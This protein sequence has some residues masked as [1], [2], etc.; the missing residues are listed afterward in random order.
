[1]PKRASPAPDKKPAN[2]GA[3][4]SRARGGKDL[5]IVESPAKAR[6]IEGILGDQYRVIASVGHVRDLP[7]YGYGVDVK[8]GSFEPTYEVLKDKKDIVKQ[9]K[10]AS[11]SAERVFLSTDP[12]REG[13]AISW[14]I[15]EAAGIP[16]REDSARRLPRDHEARH[17]SRL[18]APRRARP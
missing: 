11:A 1:M 15:L 6:T 18:P 9:I 10:D 3:R 16:G 17:R 14:H 12:D 8:G 13:E 4:T 7:S 2:R 5:V